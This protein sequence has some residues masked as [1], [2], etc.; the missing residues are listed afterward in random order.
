LFQS[1]A[2]LCVA[3]GIF[4]IWSSHASKGASQFGAG[5][6]V[7]A[8][9]YHV[10]TGWFVVAGIFIQTMA[11]I[12]KLF[13]VHL[14]GHLKWH[15]TLGPILYALGGVNV[16]LAVWFWGGWSAVFKA[17]AGVLTVGTVASALCA[18]YSDDK[19]DFE[20][21]PTETMGRSAA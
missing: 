4:C 20:T 16:L 5:L 7:G 1:A 10:Y 3:G 6:P 12:M 17:F 15:G 11:G 14:F 19:E 21:M 13:N 8:K 9:L 18:L 2:A